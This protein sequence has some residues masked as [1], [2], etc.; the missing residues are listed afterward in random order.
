MKISGLTPL[1]DFMNA[2]FNE[3]TRADAP[4]E[5]DGYLFYED[6]RAY[7]PFTFCLLTRRADILFLPECHTY[8]TPHYGNQCTCY[9]YAM[10]TAL[11][12][13]IT[14]RCNIVIICRKE[15]RESRS[16]VT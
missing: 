5:L 11:E 13:E 2:S 8:G 10:P 9:R 3:D 1:W 14:Q 16:D 15:G 6:I 4:V 12:Y 7:A